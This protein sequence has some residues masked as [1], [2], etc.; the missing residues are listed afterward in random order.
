[1]LTLAITTTGPLPSPPMTPLPPLT[2]TLP[3]PTPSALKA[4]VSPLALMALMAPNTN[5][6]YKPP[7]S[8]IPTRATLVLV[9]ASMLVLP[10]MAS[11]H[12]KAPPTSSLA[13]AAWQILP[14]TILPA[15]ATIGQALRYPLAA[16]SSC[17][18]IRV[19]YT[20]RLR[21]VASSGGPYAAWLVSVVEKYVE[22][23]T[24]VKSVAIALRLMRA[25]EGVTAP[26]QSSK[27]T[28][29]PSRSLPISRAPYHPRAILLLPTSVASLRESARYAASHQFLARYL[30]MPRNL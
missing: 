7:T 13:R 20:Q 16:R 9:T 18:T 21:T 6:S 5:F 2:V 15:T 23:A 4:G 27:A 12:L 8:P 11:P 30:Q 17:S 26:L 10:L 25:M 1:M 19:P 22:N 24:L 3:L 14:C 28:T 29:C